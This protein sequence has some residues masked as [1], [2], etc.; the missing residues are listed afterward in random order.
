MDTKENLIILRNIFYKCFFIGLLFLII[1][2][3]IYMPCRCFLANFYQTYLGINTT[4]Y[5]NMWVSFIGLIKTI[6]IFLFL[7]PALAIHWTSCCKKNQE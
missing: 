5:Y 1:A 2:A 7:V 6:L 4:T 3:V